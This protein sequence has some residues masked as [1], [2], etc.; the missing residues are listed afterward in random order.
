MYSN[1]CI[2]IWNFVYLLLYKG[3]F[4][5]SLEGKFLNKFGVFFFLGKLILDIGF[6]EEGF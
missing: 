5:K 1:V 6:W 4:W 3:W 2:Y